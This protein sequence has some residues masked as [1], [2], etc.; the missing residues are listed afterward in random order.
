MRCQLM[1]GKDKKCNWQVRD[2]RKSDGTDKIK[3]YFFID[4]AMSVLM[5]GCT[6][7]TL[8]KQL[9]KKRE[10]TPECCLLLKKIAGNKITQT[11]SSWAVYFP[12]KDLSKTNK[13]WLAHLESTDGHISSIL[14]WTSTQGRTSVGRLAKTYINQLGEKKGCSPKGLT[15]AINNRD[16]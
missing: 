2:R 14:L 12:F 5:Y 3:R 9:E 16:W 10:T 6:T 13:T 11:N 1:D 15:R 4:A 7:W 8:T